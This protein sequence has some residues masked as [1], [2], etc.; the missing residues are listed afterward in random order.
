MKIKKLTFLIGCLLCTTG[1]YS[2]GD[3]FE[4]GVLHFNYKAEELAPAEKQAREQLEK[5]LAALV[6]IPAGERT[7]EN[8]I[9]GYEKAF[10]KYSKALGM[11]GFLSYVSTDKAF[12]DKAREVEMEISQYMVDVA[13]RRDIYK[14]IR[15]YTDTN[16]KLG[17][18]EAKLVKEMLIGFR[19][20]GM[21]L[22][23]ADLEKFKALNKKEAEYVIKFDQNIQ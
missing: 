20:S 1:A 19:N 5:D 4:N 22:N 17:S 23:D 8:T 14:A 16:P 15:E 3:M 2:M 7:F 21:E 13:T 12:R 9:M 11:S 18:V 6:A 10:D